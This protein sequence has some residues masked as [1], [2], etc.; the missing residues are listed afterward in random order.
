MCLTPLL[1]SPGGLEGL[2]TDL[3]EVEGSGK[4][5]E[6]RHCQQKEQRLLGMRVLGRREGA[7][8]GWVEGVAASVT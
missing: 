2:N 5:L 4:T 1:H 7:E 3:K 8:I 6:N